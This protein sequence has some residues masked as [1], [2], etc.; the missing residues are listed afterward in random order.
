M[1]EIDAGLCVEVPHFGI[2]LASSICAAGLCD[3]V[4]F[5]AVAQDVQLE[6][7]LVDIAMVQLYLLKKK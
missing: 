3:E 1:T 2:A 7:L 5:I 4:D 6:V